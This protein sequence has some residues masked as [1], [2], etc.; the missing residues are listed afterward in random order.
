MLTI[1]D[2]IKNEEILRTLGFGEKMLGALQT[3]GIGLGVVFIVLIVLIVVI[4]VMGKMNIGGN[5]EKKAKAA[6]AAVSAP[7]PA[8]EVTRASEPQEDMNAVVAAIFAAISEMEGTNAFR[9][10]N[11]RPMTPSLSWT[12]AAMTETFASRGSQL[13]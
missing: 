4:S 8:A 11:V 7:A 6:A 1:V 13:R 12:T 9:I 2:L 10:V 3:A 5:A